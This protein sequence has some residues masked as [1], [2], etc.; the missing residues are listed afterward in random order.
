[1]IGKTEI[2]VKGARQNNLQNF[3]LNIPRDKLTVITGVSGSGKSSL[4]FDILYGEGQRRFLDSL[5]A[6][7]R[8]RISQLKKPDVD[9]VF[10]LSPVI[11]IEQKRGL[12]NPRSTV[13]TMTEIYDYLRLLFST[14]GTVKCP[15]CDEKFDI[16][17]SGEIVEAVL[18]TKQSTGTGKCS[19][20]T[21]LTKQ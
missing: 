10:G 17:S 2:E 9:F 5:P 1:M 14:V 18:L 21:R 16:R 11:A 15:Y 3:D 13:G 7:S 4:A 20:K 6:F 12:V 8:N 19:E